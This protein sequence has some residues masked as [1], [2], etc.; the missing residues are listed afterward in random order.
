MIRELPLLRK[1]ALLRELPLL[2]ELALL[3]VLAKLVV[4]NRDNRVLQSKKIH[5]KKSKQK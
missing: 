4:T 1:L 3:R 2:R 5:L